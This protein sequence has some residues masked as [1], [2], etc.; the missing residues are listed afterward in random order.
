MKLNLRITQD[1]APHETDDKIRGYCRCGASWL[2]EAVCH[3]A[4]CHLTFGSS[5]GFDEHRDR[6]EGRCRTP[7][8][9]RTRGL[10]P[11]ED[12]H[13]RKPMS[14]AAKARIGKRT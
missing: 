12:G 8:E 6:K 11:D 9:L 3:C 13:W 10:E 4:T 2:G 7:D 14:D 5:S 1:I